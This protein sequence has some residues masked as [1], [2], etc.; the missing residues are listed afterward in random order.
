MA[1]IKKSEVKSGLKTAIWGAIGTVVFVPMVL[2]A[3][4]YIRSR[5]PGATA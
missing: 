3:Y 1:F 4:N 2:V 5:L